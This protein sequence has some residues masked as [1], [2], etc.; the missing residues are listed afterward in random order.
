MTPQTR[1]QDP[2]S[3]LCRALD[4]L[5]ALQAGFARSAQP[6]AASFR[7]RAIALWHLGQGQKAWI[8]AAWRDA[9]HGCTLDPAHPQGL[10][11]LCQLAVAVGIAAA[12]RHAVALDLL[13]NPFATPRQR[14]HALDALDPAQLPAL[15][16][17]PLP[18]TERLTLLQP[19]GAGLT[20][21]GKHPEDQLSTLGRS[22]SGAVL[23]LDLVV[24]RS[25]G[26]ARQLVLTQGQTVQQLDIAALPQPGQ[27]WAP[28]P[29][30]APLWIIMPLRDGGAALD[31]ALH[32][33]L[34]DLAGL[35]GGRLVLV[36]DGSTEPRTAEAL[37]RAQRAPGVT[38]LRTA[39]GLGFT[40]AVN[41]GLGAV[42]RGP[43]LL[44]NS[45]IWLPAGSLSRLLAHLSDPEVGTVTPLS[46][47]AG[48][49]CLLGP[50]KA[51]AMPAPAQCDQ[52]A[53]AAARLNAGQAVEVP[54]GNGFAMLISEACLR[55][56]AP[57]SNL[58]ESGY[59]EEVDFCLRAS[60]RGWRHVAATDCFVGHIGS[61]T[62]GAAKRRLVS[63]NALRLEQRFP[64]YTA[65]YAGFATLAPLSAACNRLLEALAPYW[66]PQPL[67]AP[68]PPHPGGAT[69]R[70]TPP[71]TVPPT[72]P[73]V[74]P[75]VLPWQG[76]ALPAALDQQACPQL[77]LVAENAFSAGGLQ[78]DPGHALRLR[79]A[80][81]GQS[82]Q[83]CHGHKAQVLASF[84]CD[85][86]DPATVAAS[87]LALATRHATPS[88]E[89]RPDVL[90]L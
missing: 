75:L 40:G 49:F 48:S 70:L 63:G 65:T 17:L 26:L 85:G 89:D 29:E 51:S 14:R 58:Y 42:G 82:L 45:D 55:A 15:L 34:A 72:S 61:V 9:R 27:R 4:R 62:Y 81:D 3:P 32:S 12:D 7:E 64:H 28:G 66:H 18:A 46:N 2:P 22:R 76:D 84:P 16:R 86:A 44:L 33:T 35:P 87:I 38:L 53:E 24:R 20:L 43:V 59:Y 77:R 19:A 8:E 13:A 67:P 69:I 47:N 41:A 30:T 57:L 80:A 73:L 88:A 78:L 52:L 74:L 83:L 11:L 5:L 68:D 21:E 1:P 25:A 10:A 6:S 50:G 90:P 71:P 36:D 54:S 39:G 56:V 60:D 31:Q 79:M 37:A 23:A